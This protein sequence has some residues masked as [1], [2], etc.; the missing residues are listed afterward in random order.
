MLTVLDKD[1]RHDIAVEL[2][3]LVRVRHQR[4]HSF[5]RAQFHIFDEA[6]YQCWGWVEV[7]PLQVEF[8]NGGR[9]EVWTL[10]DLN[11]PRFFEE[12]AEAICRLVS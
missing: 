9:L 4:L 6:N 7:T 1:L 8:R 2:M 11:N 10:E 5:G 3:S 12:V